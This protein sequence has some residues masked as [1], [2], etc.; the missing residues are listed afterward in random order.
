V[1]PLL[2]L[3]LQAYARAVR[4][5]PWVGGLWAAGLR[6]M[7]RTGAP[8]E[9]HAALAERALAAGMQVSA[10]LHNCQ[11]VYCPTT[12]SGFTLRIVSKTKQRA[13]ALAERALAAGMQARVTLHNCRRAYCLATYL[14]FDTA[15]CAQYEAACSTDS[16]GTGCGHAGTC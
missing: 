7:E 3:L 15:Y 2:L 5:C 8:D 14:V 1:L 12:Y 9:E 6:A 10:T 13:A 11:L 4:N 16:E